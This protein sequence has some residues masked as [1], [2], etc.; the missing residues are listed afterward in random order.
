MTPSVLLSA[1]ALAG[2]PIAGAYLYD[3][4]QSGWGERHPLLRELALLFAFIVGTAML[5]AIVFLP[6]WIIWTMISSA[7]TAPM[8]YPALTG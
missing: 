2:V 3:L 4:A 7:P 5:V 8:P 6:G 1:G